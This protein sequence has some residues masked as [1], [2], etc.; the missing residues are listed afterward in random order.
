MEASDEVAKAL[1]LMWRE[2]NNRTNKFW[3]H[4]VYYFLTV[5]TFS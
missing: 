2:E 3:Y 5:R 1:L 4:K